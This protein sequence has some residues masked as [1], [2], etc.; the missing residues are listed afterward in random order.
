MDEDVNNGGALGSKY[1]PTAWCSDNESP[2]HDTTELSVFVRAM[3]AEA[4]ALE[5]TAHSLGGRMGA[6]NKE[7][8]VFGSRTTSFGRGG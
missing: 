6:L 2:N 1:F 5:E 3:R 7:A 4:N 8:G